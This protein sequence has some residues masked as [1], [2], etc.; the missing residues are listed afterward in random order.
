MTIYH[1]HHIV[2]RH[3]GGTD[4]D[5]NLV[6]LTIE[7]HAQ[8][9]LDLYHQYG[10]KQDL[11]AHKALTGQITS[12]EARRL[13]V[14]AALT[15]KSQTQEHID[16]RTASRMLTNPTPT[17]GKKLPPASDERKAKISEANKGNKSRSGLITSDET[18]QKQREAALN[19]PKFTCPCCGKIMAKAPLVRY[20]GLNGEKCKSS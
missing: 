16:K 3:A 13:A 12:D 15:G 9:H 4:D 6:Q 2:P 20:H 1:I 14:S 18:K 17:L 5:S 8:A 7:E 11:I 19:R 10:R